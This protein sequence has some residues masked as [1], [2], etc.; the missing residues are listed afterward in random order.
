MGLRPGVGVHTCAFLFENAH[1]SMR[2]VRKKMLLKVDQNGNAYTYRISGDGRKRIEMKTM[3]ENIAGTPV[4]SMRIEVHLR[5]NVQ[6]YRS[7]TF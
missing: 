5:H 6:F 7:R 4:C 1:G 2:F 3:T